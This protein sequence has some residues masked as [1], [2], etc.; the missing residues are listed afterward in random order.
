MVLDDEEGEFVVEPSQTVLEV[1]IEAD[2]DP[3]YACQSGICTTCR[4]RL[5]S[6]VVTMDVSEGLSDEEKDEGYVLACQAHP[7]TDN[8]VLDFDE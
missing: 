5:K 6:G 7:L 2:L 8:V 1:A 4:C 3:P